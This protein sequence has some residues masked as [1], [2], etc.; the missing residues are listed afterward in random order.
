MSVSPFTDL[1]D[2]RVYVHDAGTAAAYDVAERTT[3]A[4]AI[5]AVDLP[6]LPVETILGDGG[7]DLTPQALSDHALRLRR[8]LL[9]LCR[10]VEVVAGA[11]GQ[12]LVDAVRTVVDAEFPG[13]MELRARTVCLARGVAVLLDVLDGADPAHMLYEHPGGLSVTDVREAIRLVRSWQES[14][15]APHPETLREVVRRLREAIGVLLPRAEFYRAGL[16]LGSRERNSVRDLS[17]DA[18]DLAA[19]DVPEGRA[20]AVAYAAAAGE[21]A[22]RLLLLAEER[23]P[24]PSPFELTSPIAP[25]VRMR[26]QYAGRGQSVAGER[27]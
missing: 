14:G 27:S 26:K 22:H 13:V 20:E 19:N 25:P 21:F 17:A 2:F 6:R 15:T 24:V 9:P 10:E 18:E 3:P 7:Q 8:S 5:R 16:P 4:V 23:H 11:S 1:G 12:Q